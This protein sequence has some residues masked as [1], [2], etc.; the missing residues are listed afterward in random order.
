MS[1]R[2]LVPAQSF[3]RVE[4]LVKRSR[5]IVTLARASSVDEAKA[6]V[7]GIKEEFPDATHN[8]WAYAVGAPG[9]TAQIGFSDDGEPHGTA[10]RPMLHAIL[11]SDVG[12]IAAVVTRYFGGVKLGAG[13]LVRAYSSCVANA[14]TDLPVE[15]KIIPVEVWVNIDYNRVTQLKRL[16]DKFEAKVVDE[17][18]SQ[19]A[20]FGLLMP[21]ELFEAF[22]AEVVELSAG[23]A[24]ISCKEE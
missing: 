17:Q 19:T 9:D 20:E 16:F 7:A 18:F 15:E 2:Y 23:Q 21:K 13:G 12:E 11:H 24:Q 8:C 3:Y 4:E 10:G 6:F 1:E 5:F 22:Y 14:L